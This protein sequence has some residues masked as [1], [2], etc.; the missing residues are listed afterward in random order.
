[1][2]DLI[3][4]SSSGQGRGPDL[5]IE[6]IYFITELESDPMILHILLTDK[7]SLENT[8]YPPEETAPDM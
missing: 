7:S 2:S 4:I 5:K 1:M 8:W 6:N 3:K